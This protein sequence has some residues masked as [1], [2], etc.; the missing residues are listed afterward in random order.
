MTIGEVGATP[1]SGSATSFGGPAGFAFD[2]E[3]NEVF[4][5]DGYAN[6]RVAV[7]DMTTG[8][9]KRSWGTYGNEPDDSESVPYDPDAP[10][11]QQF[12]AVTCVE[13]SN[14]GLLYVC[15][16]GNNRIQVFRTDGTFVTEALVAPGT[17]G[18]GSVSD[19][20][21]SPDP[22]QSFLY[23]ADAMNERVAI[24][25]RESL[26][27]RTS[28]GVGGR[29]PSHFRQLGS[30]AV[31]AQGNVYTAEDGQGRRVQKF[32][33]LGMGPVTAE[34]QGALYPN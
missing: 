12:R 14:D 22:D 21:F 30:V 19:I 11:S 1:S 18:T 23:V 31:D 13:L 10:P 3:A 25:D 34:H 33:Y 2:A 32:V 28:F 16:R 7:L 6:H 20:A 5:A 27:F 24:L 8:D 9:L 29:Y 17:L 26:T 15:D 4:V